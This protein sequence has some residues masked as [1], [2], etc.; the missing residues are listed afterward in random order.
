MSITTSYSGVTVDRALAD[1]ARPKLTIVSNPPSVVTPVECAAHPHS[2]L[3]H[4]DGYCRCF[5]GG[6][7]P[8]FQS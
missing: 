8:E 2:G 4:L 3:M 1:V 5:F 6:E 7:P